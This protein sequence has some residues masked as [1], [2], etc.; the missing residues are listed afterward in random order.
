M[1]KATPTDALIF[2]APPPE[3]LPEIDEVHSSVAFTY[4]KP[5]AEALAEAWAR[6][7]L[8][9]SMGGPAFNEPGGD[10]VPGR[11]LREGYVITSRGCPTRGCWFCAVP[12][13]EGGKLRELPIVPGYLV[14]DDNLLAC[15]DAHIR[16]VFKMLKQQK[17]RPR[18]TGGLEAA[19]LRPWHV[20]HL[21]EV[22]TEQMYFSYDTPDDLDPLIDA[23]RLLAANG[24]GRNSRKVGCYVLIGY[25][26]DSFEAAEKRL[27][28]AWEAGF[29]PCAML[30]RDESGETDRKWRS[31]QRE[32]FRPPIMMSKL[33]ELYS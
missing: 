7:G 28:A 11:Y 1:T 4:D 20:E 33:A 17:N 23:G 16:G 26:S 5:K 25:P 29:R 30:Y 15:S 6:T 3:N 24:F 13:R 10:F 12:S 31:F 8:P 27:L 22:K 18:F 32:W 21:R 2:T 19:R 9:V 14:Q